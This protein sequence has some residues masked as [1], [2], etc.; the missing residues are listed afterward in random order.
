MRGA[1]FE[2]L[3][4]ELFTRW[5]VPF[6]VAS[7]VLLVALIGAFLIAGSEGG[8]GGDSGGGGERR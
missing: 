3:G 4:S 1:S 2:E 8:R 7:L 6:E 5:A